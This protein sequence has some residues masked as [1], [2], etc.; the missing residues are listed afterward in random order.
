MQIDKQQ[1][2]FIFNFEITIAPQ[3]NILKTTET[4]VE[5]KQPKEKF[6]NNRWLD[7]SISSL[8]GRV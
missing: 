8:M 2:Q 6:I 3:W 1:T 4:T 7:I 5:V